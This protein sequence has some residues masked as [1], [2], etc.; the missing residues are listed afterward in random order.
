V[1]GRRL[2][3]LIICGPENMTLPWCGCRRGAGDPLRCRKYGRWLRAAA[4]LATGA[5]A[6]V[7]LRRVM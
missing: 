3:Q 6:Y 1:G 2:A 4:V 7:A 5:A